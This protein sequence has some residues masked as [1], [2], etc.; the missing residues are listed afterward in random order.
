MGKQQA[1][2]VASIIQNVDTLK[3]SYED[4]KNSAGTAM[5]EQAKLSESVEF[6]LNALKET[7]VGIAQNT[8][9]SDIFKGLIDGATDGV[10]A[11]ESFAKSMGGIGTITS[12][13]TGYLALFNSKFKN[14]A[15]NIGGCISPIN[16]LQTKLASQTQTLKTS[17]A[18]IQA[19]R[20]E[21]IKEIA[22]K[23]ASGEATVQ[24]SRKLTTLNSALTTTKASLVATELATVALQTAMSLGLSV[25]ITGIVTGLSKIINYS[26]DTR[27]ALRE[28]NSEYLNQSESQFD[29]SGAEKQLKAY[30]QITKELSTL[31]PNTEAYKEKEEELLGVKESL[32]S[33][34]PESEE[35]FK[36]LADAKGLDTEATQELIDKEAE[37]SR[38]EANRVLSKN[39]ISNV[40]DIREKIAN[41]DE[42]IE[43][44]KQ[45]DDAY[46]NGEKYVDTVTMKGV[47]A[48]K[49]AGEEL[50]GSYTKIAKAQE[51][52]SEKSSDA[53]EQI[54]SV[55]K[56][57]QYTNAPWA[58]E[59]LKELTDTYGWLKSGLNELP[60]ATDGADESLNKYINTTDEGTEST[61]NF[62]DAV[63]GLTDSFNGLDSGIDLLNS[64]IEELSSY[65]DLTSDTFNKVLNSGN[66]ELIALL[67]DSS[68]AQAKAQ[69][70]LASYQ[71]QRTNVAN[72]IIASAVNDQNGISNLNNE[73]DET[74]Q[75]LGEVDQQY[76][77]LNSILSEQSDTKLGINVGEI[78]GLDEAVAKYQ[79]AFGQIAIGSD[80]LTKEMIEGVRQYVAEGGELYAQDANNLKAQAEAK[81]QASEIWKNEEVIDLAQMV[82][83]NSSNYSSDLVN[84]S[85]LVLK[86]KTEGVNF[87]DDVINQVAEM[88]S[89]N[90]NNYSADLV[91]WSNAVQNKSQ[92]NANMVN[93]VMKNIA[94]MILA[95]GGNYSSDTKNWASA[96]N[97]KDKNNATMC[98]SITQQMA[99]ALNNLNSQYGVDAQNFVDATNTK[100]DAYNSFSVSLRNAIKE[101]AFS[102]GTLGDALN[103]TGEEAK[104]VNTILD[105]TSQAYADYMNKVNNTY[106][107]RGVTGTAIAGNTVAGNAV[108]GNAGSG[109]GSSGGKGSSSSSKSEELKDLKDRYISLN[110]VIADN[111]NALK[112]NQI[113]LDQTA[114]DYY[115]Q[116]KPIEERIKLY[117][118][119]IGA[120]KK[121]SIAYQQE[122]EE[123]KKQIK[124]K[125]GKIDK[126]NT[127]T[128]YN[129]LVNK[130]ATNEEREAMK[131]LMDRFYELNNDLIP[132]TEASWRGYYTEI[133]E[134][135][136]KQNKQYVE[137]LE[138]QKEAYIS[139][140]EKQ[141]DALKKNLEQR[142]KL[143]E[144][145]WDTED[146]EDDVA[147]QQTNINNL[148]AQ[149]EIARRTGN[150][151]LIKDL[152]TQIASA[153]E[154][155]NKT[156]R[157]AERDYATNKIDEEIEKIDEDYSNVIDN[158]NEQ[159]DDEALLSLV[160]GGLKDLTS[161]LDKIK[162]ST[163]TVNSTFKN[164]GN[165]IANDWN[166]GLD[167]TISKL[168]EVTALQNKLNSSNAKTVATAKSGTN[169]IN[170]SP[171][172]NI[173]GLGLNEEQVQD[174]VDI[175]LEK[176]RKALKDEFN[177]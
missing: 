103:K 165:T 168:K 84:W 125:G 31:T 36:N 101:Q 115:S 156:I 116:K 98:T 67:A 13:G 72:D 100:I 61:N 110:K 4:A 175:S 143:L 162:N 24:Q 69:E 11:I 147:N 58:T 95:N 138:K 14:L 60:G 88:I 35:L 28:V 97:N 54:E 45:L 120:T 47:N 18:N 108:G 93:N 52:I 134:L 117:E 55:A 64:I 104:K 33:I 172:I 22:A 5:E 80:D 51:E 75:K 161:T 119:Q 145:T 105:K 10:K 59:A 107:G 160:Q 153:K 17:I 127:I 114:D 96:I 12:V 141:R 39:D 76:K 144:S 176:E 29:Q 151:V 78:S 62:A 53:K 158:I 155:L 118:K 49:Q 23:Q 177:W 154:E 40:D 121:L 46:A 83:A 137:I 133:Y 91:N 94:T 89:L 157:D 9:N 2:V 159:L 43:K 44:Q 79:D 148:E 56:A 70:L 164:V 174:V 129:S 86:K 122:R 48:T 124:A 112:Y 6:K 92:N 113:V 25:A 68:T 66:S 74:T 63:S 71:T 173:S 16:S 65:G 142:K 34:L 42:L 109:S 136:E 102:G 123:L 169:T 57:L 152:E 30:K 26:K 41:Y 3:S 38:S 149:L 27:E 150:E 132:K 15:S 146:K 73:L 111:D 37:L 131:E 128:N 85:N 21:L 20:S 171:T 81:K 7:I 90:A 1:A 166:S 130:G 167:D 170:Y 32:I 106:S 77:D 87:S 163:G 140:L 82:A 19:E 50:S 139:N 8:V 135:Q 126:L 99:Q